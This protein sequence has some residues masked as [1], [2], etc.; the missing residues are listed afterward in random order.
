MAELNFDELKSVLG[1]ATDLADLQAK[2]QRHEDSIWEGR[3]ASPEPT[4][5]PAN[6]VSRKDQAALN[7]NFEKIASGEITVVD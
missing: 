2:I 6:Q 5:L 7:A 1:T 4:L 3:Y